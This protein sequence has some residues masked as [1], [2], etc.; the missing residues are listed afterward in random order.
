MVVG[1]GVGKLYKAEK[2]ADGMGM[3]MCIVKV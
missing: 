2:S 3:A 1:V